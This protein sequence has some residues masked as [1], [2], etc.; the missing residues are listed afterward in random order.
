[1]ST[2]NKH[3]NDLNINEEGR[4]CWFFFV[5]ITLNLFLKLPVEESCPVSSSRCG[6]GW[7]SSVT[8]W[9]L[10]VHLLGW[11]NS[12]MTLVSSRFDL[13]TTRLL[14]QAVFRSLIILIQI[15]IH[16]VIIRIWINIVII[17]IRINIVIIRIRIHIV[18]IQIRIYIVIIQ[19]LIN[20]VIIRNRCKF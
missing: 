16:I 11:M 20:I 2:D 19:I 17:R 6:R 5:V 18:I 12:C 7:R 13:F 10:M 15:R 8:S 14:F 4:P 3:W 9:S 1:M